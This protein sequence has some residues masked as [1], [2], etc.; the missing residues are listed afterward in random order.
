M[1]IFPEIKQKGKSFMY[2]APKRI[3]T[4]ALV[5]LTL[6]TPT[7]VF[8]QA[9][10]N[11]LVNTDP[12]GSLVTIS[13]DL[14][15]SGV[16]PVQFDR[17]LSGKYRVEVTRDGYENYHSTAYFSSTQVT[18]LDIRLVPKRRI[19]AFAR[20]LI[21]P[22]WG[23]KYYGN[24]YKAALF[25]VGTVASAVGYGIVRDD[26]NT[27]KDD[28]EARK[29]AYEDATQWSDLPRLQTEML[30][31]QKEAN[32][33]ENWVN[34]MAGV[35]IGVYALNLLDSFLLFPEYSS[36]TEYKAITAAPAVGHDRVGL[37]VSLNF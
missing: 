24:G 36:F 28:Y 19:K 22:G 32:D 9:E 29:S 12:Q 10:G 13:G 16:S 15:L 2:L 35:T 20:S 7:M 25:F 37:T 30:D 26:Y 1:S 21:I 33:A 14:T 23:Q 31:A 11:V 3:L 4:A 6:L 17:A 34:I 5:C 8:A 18:Q 27:K